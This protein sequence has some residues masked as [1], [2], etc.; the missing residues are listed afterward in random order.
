MQAK[1]LPRP[2]GVVWDD[3]TRC[4]YDVQFYPYDAPG[5]DP[6]FAATG[7]QRVY[8]CRL[9]KDKNDQIEMLR[10]FNDQSKENDKP[11]ELN[12]VAW[13]KDMENDN[14]LL[15]VAGVQPPIIKILDILED[16]H[17]RDLVGHGGYI[18]DLKVSPTCPE[19]LASI[20]EDERIYIWHLGAKYQKI[21]VAAMF[22]GAA[23]GHCLAFHDSGRYVISGWYDSTIQLWALPDLPNENTGTD[24]VKPTYVPHFKSNEIHANEVDSIAFYG[25]MVISKAALEDYIFIW[26]IEGFKGSLPP[27]QCTSTA[28]YKDCFFREDEDADGFHGS[29]YSAFGPRFQRLITLKTGHHS[30]IWLRFGLFHMPQ[31]RPVLAYGANDG[32]IYFW[33]L[34]RLEEECRDGDANRERSPSQQSSRFGSPGGRSMSV[35]SNGSVRPREKPSMKTKSQ[36]YQDPFMPV[37]AH[38]S[39]HLPNKIR[40]DRVM[41][42]RATA[43]SNGGEWVV[44]VGEG[45]SDRAGKKGFICLMN[46]WL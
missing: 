33:D 4:L 32:V 10:E 16:K 9:S 12:S 6:V 17:T 45:H 24:N 44:S 26:R 28:D 31:K 20:S 29:T 36:T 19:I 21:P 11:T 13:T 27:P 46:R 15:C 14:P 35:A 30:N 40:Q 23:K 3:K 42:T 7:F 2:A 8:V 41:T 25:D 37:P 1:E 43:W 18:N 38:K 22:H 5:E 34:Q 39:L